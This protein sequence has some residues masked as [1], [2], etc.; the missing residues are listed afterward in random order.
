[1]RAVQCRELVGIEGLRPT[2]LPTPWPGACCVRI[3]VRAAGVNFADGLMIAGRYQERP[4]LPFVPGLEVAGEIDALGAAVHGL[5]V[6]QRVLAILGHGG[7]AEQA[8]A[9]VDD[10]VPIPDEMDFA[11]AAGFAIAYGTAYGGLVWRAGL[12]GGETL[13]VHGAAGGVGS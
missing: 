7:F 13:L 1:M 9:R 6:G 10:V 11:I 3:R 12:H 8:I 2:E 4:S 5:E